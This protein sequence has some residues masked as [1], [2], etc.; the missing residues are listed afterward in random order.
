MI[1][2]E[3]K[4]SGER[5]Y[6]GKILSVRKDLVTAVN[7]QA[8]R[9]IVE[10]GGAVAMVAVT[11]DDKIIMVR[12]YRYACGRAVLEIPAGKIDPGEKDP[13]DVAHR[14][15]KEETGYSA[16]SVTHLGD[17]NPSCGYSE[18]VIHIYLMK[19]LTAGEQEPDE[20]EAL[21]VLE[22]PFDEVYAK[23]VNGEI[24]D[25]KTMAALLMAKE[26]R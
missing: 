24:A 15:L 7:G 13:V 3:K 21:E 10:H 19:G 14:E 26:R 1:F 23:A 11:E 18:E 20:D 4:I 22:L 17:V 9:E 16:S 2:E 12:Q 5:I 25:A 6:Q 8:Y